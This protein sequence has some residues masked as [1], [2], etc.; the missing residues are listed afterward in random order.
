MAIDPQGFGLVEGTL[1]RASLAGGPPRQ[2]ARAVVAADW[3][4][5]GGELAAV[6]SVSGHS[7]LQYPLG[8]TLYDPS[9]GNITHIRFSPSG[10]A[11]AFIQHPVPG[12]TA[13]S[14]MLTDLNGRATVLS[15]GWNSVLGLG[16]SP[17]GREVWFTGTR[18][19]AAH[20]LYAVT[21][22][23]RE[24]LL[25]RA[26]ATLTLH[27][28]SRDGRVLL[29]RDAW[30]AGVIAL[31][32][33]AARER[34]LSWL[35]GSTAWDLSADGTTMILEES[36]EAGGAERGIYL[37]TTDGGPPYDWAKESPLRC[38]PTSSG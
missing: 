17:D 12:D 9:P 26:P 30:G 2:L 28:V 38:H 22:T 21:R 36:W 6:Q 15:K 4:P 8:K 7:L 3:S 20:A 5:N 24:R 35:D 34:D 29:T 27:D 1:A 23:G 10:D 31:T 13:G 14:V 25:V 37:R 16:W 19:G 18:V 32:P 33:G 11:I